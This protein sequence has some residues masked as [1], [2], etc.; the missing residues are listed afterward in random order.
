MCSSGGCVRAV[1]SS[2][3]RGIPKKDKEEGYLLQGHGLQGDAHAGNDGRQVSIL[4]EQYVEPVSRQLGYVP[5]PGS[6]A[7]N[8]LVGGLPEDGLGRGTVLKVGEAVVEI[9]AIG[10]DSTAEHTY[11]FEGYSLLAEKGLF[12]RVIESGL[13]RTGDAVIILKK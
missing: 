12:G 5:A 4:L 1:C 13:A 7:E 10:K 6:F 2:A 3:A 9:T 8:L 11:S